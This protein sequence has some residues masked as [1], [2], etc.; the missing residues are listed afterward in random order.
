MK[1]LYKNSFKKV[2]LASSVGVLLAMSHSCEREEVQALPE[3]QWE[4]VWSDEFSGESGVLP[5]ETK[6][7][8]DIGTGENGWGNQELQYYTN[9]PENVSLD[10]SGNLVIT[11]KKENYSGAAYTSARIKTQ[12]LFSR[13]YGKIEARIKTPYGPGL[14]PAFWM[15]GNNID[16]QG[17]PKCSEID[18]MELKGNIPNVVHG[19]LHGPGYSAGNAVTKSYGL[20]NSRFD[21]DFHVFSVE[22]KKDQIDFFVD[23]YLYQRVTA[24]DV[25]GEW[26][27]NQPFF[28]ILNTAVGGNFVGFPTD[29]TTFPQKM[30]IDYVRVYKSK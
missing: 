12:G 4:L 13:T 23:G 10:G 28:L 17:W 2:L 1:L 6:W 8:Y 24:K 26:V 20:K 30:Y 27:Y 5:D 21:A 19:S 11:A 9:R 25:P 15:L 3:R 7:T 22:W 16:T 18:I 29:G 14:W